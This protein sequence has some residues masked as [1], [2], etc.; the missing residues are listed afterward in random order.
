M[1]KRTELFATALEQERRM[2]CHFYALS[3]LLKGDPISQ[4]DF[5]KQYPRTY[6]AV[7]TDKPYSFD[8][9]KDYD[10]TPKKKKKIRTRP[11]QG[12]RHPG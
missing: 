2:M 6:N 8:L 5:A 10:H 3:E 7:M 4:E 1:N 9:P 12:G 11:G